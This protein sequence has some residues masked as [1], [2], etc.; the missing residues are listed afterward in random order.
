MKLQTGL[1]NRTK[2][3]FVAGGYD[4]QFQR[5]ANE[6]SKTSHIVNGIYIFSKFSAPTIAFLAF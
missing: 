1:T 3:S 5:N 6:K 2:V 4:Q